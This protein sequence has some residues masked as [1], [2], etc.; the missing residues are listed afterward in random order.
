MKNAR[1]E[2][3][4]IRRITWEEEGCVGKKNAMGS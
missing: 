3:N 1:E 4:M 2:K